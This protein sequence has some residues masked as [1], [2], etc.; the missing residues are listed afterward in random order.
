[1]SSSWLWSLLSFPLSFGQNDAINQIQS[2]K[3]LVYE[4]VSRT[5]IRLIVQAF[6]SL[7]LTA[8]FLLT[9]FKDVL[10]KGPS[11]P[12]VPIKVVYTA[13]NNLQES[14]FIGQGIAGERFYTTAVLGTQNY[15]ARE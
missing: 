6:F 13:T 12:K 7:L 14:N 3:E 10:L 8:F 5:Y 15:Y 1:M 11:C 9:A 2:Q 4:D